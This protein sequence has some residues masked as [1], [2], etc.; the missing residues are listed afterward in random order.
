M[1]ILLPIL[2]LIGAVFLG[3]YLISTGP[4]AKKK[5]FVER[6]PVVEVTRLK[7]QDYTVLLKTSGLVKAG[8]QTNI[9][10]EVSGSVIKLSDVF[11][12]GNY[13][14]KGEVLLTL[15]STNYLNALSIAKSEVVANR[16]TLNQLIE[17][18]K[19]SKR[20]LRLSRKNLQLGQS[21]VSR[22]RGLVKKKLI[23]RS[24]V[25][26]EEQ[27]VNQLQQ[28]LEEL[29]GKINTFQSRKA[30]TKA[31][32]ESALIRQQQEQLNISRTVIK[33]PYAGRVLNK[34]VDIGQFV[35][36][37]TSLGTIYATDFV[38]VDLPLSL[39]QYDLLGIEENFQNKTTAHHA[40][41]NIQFTS[42][43]ARKKSH[44]NG[45]I[46]RT[47][48]ALDAD[49]RQIKVI[50]KIENP[51][52]AQAGVSAPIRIG[53]YLDAEIEGRTFTNV[54]VLNASSVRQ[55]KEILL[56]REGK[57]AVIPVN[58]LFN[59]S[60][61]TIIKTDEDIEGEQLL[62]TRM[63]QATDGMKVITLAEKRRQQLKERKKHKNKGKRNAIPSPQS[64]LFDPLNSVG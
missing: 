18:E 27:K 22:L 21:E 9:V 61:V 34:K 30:V 28:R 55:N 54:Y 56:L 13:F 7:K 38:T 29:Q 26:V 5:P 36:V 4:E 23:S 1:K 47:S 57:L 63:T 16:A 8:T 62:I 32:I 10:S 40:M 51:F 48:A 50:A 42:T 52:Q 46:I 53:Q 12:E 35:R 45:R 3:K 20:S 60:K 33:A 31:K 58:V 24:R 2:V 14:D 6:L 44:W 43:N 19:S 15:D 59:T 17:E 64:M 41:P 49:S 37:G 39:D 11:N 25:D